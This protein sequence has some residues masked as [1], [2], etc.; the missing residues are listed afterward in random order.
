[1]SPKVNLKLRCVSV[2]VFVGIGAEVAAIGAI[3]VPWMVYTI[4]YLIVNS[5]LT[6]V[7]TAAFIASIFLASMVY[8]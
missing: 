6:I 1:M 5:M 4:V 2:V 3:L 8:Y 7:I